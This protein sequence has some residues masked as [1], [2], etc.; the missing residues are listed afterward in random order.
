MSSSRAF[1]H[2]LIKSEVFTKF[3]LTSTFP[4]HHD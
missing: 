2:A 1:N 4:P 3:Q